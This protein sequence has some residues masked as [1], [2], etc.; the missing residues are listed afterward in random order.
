MFTEFEIDTMM[1]I[2]SIKEANF[3]LK[4]DF[5]KNEVHYL[6]ISDHDFFSLVMMTPTLGIALADGKVS[7]TEELALN[8][9][10]RKLSTGSFYFL[11][12]DPVVDAMKFLLKKY[13]NWSDKFLDVLK[14]AIENSF[15]FASIEKKPFDPQQEVSYEQYKT[16]V[17]KTPYILIR[18]I[19]SFFLEKEEDII[20]SSRNVRK[21]EYD[22]ILQIGKAVG[23]EEVPV[24]QQFLKTFQIK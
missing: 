17:L 13:D 6:E 16:E 18:F 14:V 9:K 5:I 22:R 15:D 20:N 24:F 12:K 10:A 7:L 1:E 8:K 19:A 21:S 4:K 11:K 23:L 2:S 3:E